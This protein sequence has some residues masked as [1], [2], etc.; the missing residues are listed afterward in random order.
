MSG[1]VATWSNQDHGYSIQSGCVVRH[2]LLVFHFD[3]LF[4]ALFKQGHI[5]NRY[6]ILE[7]LPHGHLPFTGYWHVLDLDFTCIWDAEAGVPHRDRP[8]FDCSCFYW[9]PETLTLD[10]LFTST[11]LTLILFP[12]YT[13]LCLCSPPINFLDGSIESF[14][15]L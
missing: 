11:T 5:W 6:G 9:V 13:S 2:H 3:V 4:P 10:V 1:W 12:M 15:M 14:P 8:P 7:G